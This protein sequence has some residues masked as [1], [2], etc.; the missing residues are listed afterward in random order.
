MP[1]PTPAPT[2]KT[3]ASS[4]VAVIPHA[5][6]MP[7]QVAE[8]CSWEPHCPIS[9]N[10]EEHEEDWDG[11]MQREQA[12]NQQC[13]QPQNIQHPS[14]K[15]LST[16]NHKALSMPSHKTISI[17]SHKTSST[18]KPSMSLTDTPNKYD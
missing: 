5:M 1:T 3:E 11:D 10:E 17:S 14:N 2:V 13:P 9:K 18:S 7:K 15:T 6:V 12:R 8:K 16:P 4:Q